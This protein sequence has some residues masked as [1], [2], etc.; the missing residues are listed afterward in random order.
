MAKRDYYEVLGIAKN[1]NADEI[2]KSFRNTARKLHPDNKDSGDEAAFKELAE[3][4]EVLSDEKKRAQYDRY[5]HAGVQG[6]TRGFDN[7]DFSSFAGFGIDDIIDMFFGGGMRSNARRGGPE[8][9]ANLKYDLQVEFLEAVF[10]C[11]KKITIRRLEDCEPCS[12]S[13][14]QPGTTVTPCTTCAGMGQVQQVMNSWF[15]QSV[16][17]IECPSC[18]GTGQKIEKPCKDCHGEGQQRKARD[19]DVKIPAGIEPGARMR[20]TSGG[21]KGRRGG[22]FGDLY[23]IIHVREDKTFVRDGETIHIRQP[24]SF[25]MA[26]LGGEMLVPS[27][28]GKRPL[29]IPAGIQ[30]G[31][32]LVMR[33]LGVP[34]FNSPVGKRGDQIVHVIVDTPR[35]PS[36][37]ERALLQQLATVRGENLDL[38][39]EERD[40]WEA[41]QEK[42]AA[43]GKE[44][45]A[46]VEKSSKK[47]AKAKAGKSDEQVK[48]ES[49]LDK[50]GDFF[51]PKNGEH[52]DK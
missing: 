30:S 6:A 12:G 5:G 47:G 7:V 20:L 52:D 24:I 42:L 34:R 33:D 29:R 31:T 16:R 14:A 11:E 8:A 35:K 3:A 48:E 4:Y 40:A 50:L 13:G 32:T 19:F 51:R 21:D 25:S 37:E 38:T 9:G 36:D 1:A 41:E 23:V 43:N 27:V 18:Q 46:P 15:G 22:P 44:A 28:D 49:I 45:K 10:G 17:V 39:K 2:K 26:G